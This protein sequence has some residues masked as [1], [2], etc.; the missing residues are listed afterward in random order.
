MQE[1]I[2]AAR[3][4][5]EY[6]LVLCGSGN[7][8]WRLDN[9]RMLITTSNSWMA[10]LSKENVAVCRIA[11]CALLN[12]DKAS[13]EV[14]FHAAILHDRPDID[15]VLHFQS[16]HATTLACRLPQVENFF[17][18][19]EI[20]YYIGPVASVPYLTPGTPG[21]AEA[22][23]SAIKK[24]DLA[25]LRNHG[26]VT[27]GKTFNGVIEKAM[28]FELACRIILDGGDGVKPL[29]SEAVADLR[30]MRGNNG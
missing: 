9:E 7:L 2:H 21:L 10:H 3:R 17:V 24:H 13:K 20:P 30:R 12:G 19:P 16:P 18:I 5:A 14:R 11:D 1:F 25:V 4:M 23:T 28:Y 22:V 27:V 8:S 6:G 26:Q 15:V 29:S